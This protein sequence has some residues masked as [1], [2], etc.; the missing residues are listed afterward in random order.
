MHPDLE[1]IV[2]EDEIGRATVDAAAAR[3]QAR[4]EASRQTLAD[5]RQARLR[6]LQERLAAAVKAIDD[7]TERAVMNRRAQRA[8]FERER[9]A[10]SSATIDDAAAVFTAIVREGSIGPSRT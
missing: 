4:L 6:E 10:R 9:R 8:S 3:S 5:A 2:T 7:E 1:R